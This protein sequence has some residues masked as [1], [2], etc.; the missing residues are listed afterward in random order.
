MTI[1]R[2]HRSP[3]GILV[4][5]RRNARESVGTVVEAWQVEGDGP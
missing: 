1:A 2:L 5:D 4:I 3:A